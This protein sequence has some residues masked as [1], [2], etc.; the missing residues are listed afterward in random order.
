MLDVHG[1]LLE[2]EAMVRARDPASLGPGAVLRMTRDLEPPVLD[3]GFSSLNVIPFVRRPRAGHGR[4]AE[5]LALE[6]AERGVRPKGDPALVFGWRPG[7]SESELARMQD[8][9]GVAV[10]CCPHP[11]GPPRCWCRP[12]LPGLLIEFAL[13]HQ[14]DPARSVVLGTKP[15]HAALARV[16]GAEYHAA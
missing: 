14:V 3:E 13:R 16:L 12:P 4:T 8:D 5:F 7:I 9:F 11:G 6:L 2:P 15:A 10:R 1:R